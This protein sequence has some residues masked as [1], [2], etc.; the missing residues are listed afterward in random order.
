MITSLMFFY[1]K[2]SAR[3]L[4]KF[5]CHKNNL[6]LRKRYSIVISLLMRFWLNNI[7]KV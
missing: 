3:I 5:L 6:I 1:S 4:K 7:V 2:L